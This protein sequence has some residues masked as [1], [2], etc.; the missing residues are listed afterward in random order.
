MQVEED[1]EAEGSGEV[2]RGCDTE[3]T[4]KKWLHLFLSVVNVIKVQQAKNQVKCA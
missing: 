4:W 2:L 3:I 1:K